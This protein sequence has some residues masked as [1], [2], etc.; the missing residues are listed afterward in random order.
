MPFRL[1]LSCSPAVWQVRTCNGFSHKGLYIYRW[2]G[3]ACNSF[4]IV[5]LKTDHIRLSA[6]LVGQLGEAMFN[7]KVH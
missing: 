3:V 5:L 2:Q 1:Y 7:L 6:L 4:L